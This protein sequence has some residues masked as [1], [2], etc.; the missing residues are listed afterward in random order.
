MSTVQEIYEKAVRPLAVVDRL[1]LATLIL[2][3]IPREAVVDYSDGWTD[4]DIREFQHAS[5]TYV[6]R[7]LEEGDA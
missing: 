6:E 5:A 2:K 7:R 4:A 1:E 3:D